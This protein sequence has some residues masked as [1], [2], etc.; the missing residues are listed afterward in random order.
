MRESPTRPNRGVTIRCLVCGIEITGSLT[1][2]GRVM[3]S[4]RVRPALGAPVID[5]LCMT[6]AEKGVKA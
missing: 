3:P 2:D 6:H 5:G 1:D 4:D